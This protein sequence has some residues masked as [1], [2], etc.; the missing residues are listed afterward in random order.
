[1]LADNS[2]NLVAPD[3]FYAIFR[4]AGDISKFVLTAGFIGIADIMVSSVIPEPATWALLI[5]G[6]G[7]VGLAARRRKAAA[8]A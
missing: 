5:S 4:P 1:M 7:L 2:G 6:F 3:T 8:T